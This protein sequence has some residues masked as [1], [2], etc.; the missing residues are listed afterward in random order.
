[1]FVILVPGFVQ[2]A[3]TMLLL[4]TNHMPGAVVGTWFT[5]M[6][7][8]VIVLMCGTDSLAPCLCVKAAVGGE[9]SIHYSIGDQDGVFQTLQ[10]NDA[11]PFPL[12]LYILSSKIDREPQRW[13]IQW[14]MFSASLN[15]LA[16]FTKI[17]NPQIFIQSACMWF[18]IKVKHFS[19]DRA[20]KDSLTW[21]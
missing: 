15:L 3:F 21:D 1:M 9:N 10:V 4:T 5:E 13:L 2:Q 17:K 7:K 12:V 18:S 8:T 6:N 11:S 14:H 19:W 16:K 20:R